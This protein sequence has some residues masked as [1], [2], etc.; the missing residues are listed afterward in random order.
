[1][2]TLELVTF[3][4][5]EMDQERF[6]AANAEV[7]DWLRR[8]PGFLARHLAGKDDGGWI[9][10]VLWTDREA[11]MQASAKLL[12]ELGSCEAMTAIDPRSIAM[13]H[14]AIRMSSN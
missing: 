9:D 1:M 11:A 3:R 7:N 5:T 12:Q 8:Q 10:M 2:Q 14:A 4:T 6:I 13:S